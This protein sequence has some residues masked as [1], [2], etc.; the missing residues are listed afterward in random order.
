MTSLHR[1]FCKFDEAHN[2]GPAHARKILQ[3]LFNRGTALPMIDQ[4]LNRY[5]GPSLM[6]LCGSYFHFPNLVQG[7]GDRDPTFTQGF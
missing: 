3:K 2:L 1:L 7:F 5:S 4:S 6:N